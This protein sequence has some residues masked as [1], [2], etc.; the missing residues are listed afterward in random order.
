MA[1]KLLDGVTADTDGDVFAVS[2]LTQFQDGRIPVMSR[3]TDF[4]GGTVT[5]YA[6][7]TNVAAELAPVENG[8][9][10]ES[11]VKLLELPRSWYAQARLTGATS[12]DAVTVAAGGD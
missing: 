2:E 7:P 6:G 5:I 9:F 10:T 4:G 12:P 8:T 3:S 11:L 1:V